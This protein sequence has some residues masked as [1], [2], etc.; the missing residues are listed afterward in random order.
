MDLYLKVK[1]FIDPGR[2]IGLNC[3]FD[4]RSK[5]Q[6]GKDRE[7]DQEKTGSYLKNLPPASQFFQ[8]QLGSQD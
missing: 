6:C 1:T 8:K 7:A 5:V 2:E 3:G 4:K